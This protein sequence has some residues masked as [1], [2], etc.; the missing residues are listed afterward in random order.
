MFDKHTDIR[1]RWTCTQSCF[2]SA[3]APLPG[4]FL[5]ELVT[6]SPS[7]SWIRPHEGNFLSLFSLCADCA[8]TVLLRQVILCD[9]AKTHVASSFLPL[10]HKFKKEHL[11]PKVDPSAAQMTLFQC[12]CAH[13]F[14]Q[15]SKEGLYLNN[16]HSWGC[17][18]VQFKMYGCLEHACA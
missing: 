12:Q 16:L 11:L 18:R 8:R 14:L 5:L 17:A 1:S 15:L 2:F 13:E 6:R 10:S 9:Y 3:F 4:F 7:V